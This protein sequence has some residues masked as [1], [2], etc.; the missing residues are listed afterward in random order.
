MKVQY[1]HVLKLVSPKRNGVVRDEGQLLAFGVT[2][3]ICATR[4]STRRPWPYIATPRSGPLGD[5]A[6]R[7]LGVDER[8][9]VPNLLGP[10][11]HRD[12]VTPR[13]DVRIAVVI[14]G[15]KGGVGE[16][17]LIII[18]VAEKVLLEAGG[19]GRE[20]LDLL[21]RRRV[22]HGVKVERPGSAF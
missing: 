17:P 6:R 10:L 2:V 13:G 15:V 3:C 4:S 5:L 16:V 9:A 12:W 11:A 21:P 14:R 19:V 7:Q 8:V 1:N 18:R 22:C 20:A